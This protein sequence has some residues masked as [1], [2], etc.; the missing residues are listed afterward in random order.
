MKIDFGEIE[1]AF[2]FMS[3]GP[4]Y[5]NTV[6]LSRETG[7]MYYQSNYGDSD[8]LPED[9]DDDKYI[10][11]PDKNELDLGKQLALRFVTA[12]MPEKIDKVLEIFNRKGAYARYKDLLE[13][14]GKLDKWYAYEN[15]A[16]E[17]ALKEWCSSNNIDIRG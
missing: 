1:N 6:V 11:L 4:N 3:M 10:E 17:R 12:F 7:E 14:E 13:Y 15:E 9:I 8:E 5:G 2:L 16:Q